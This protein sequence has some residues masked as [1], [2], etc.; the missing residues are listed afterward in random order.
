[1]TRMKTQILS[2]CCLALMVCHSCNT[3]PNAAADLPAAKFSA[4]LELPMAVDY[5]G[6][7]MLRS[8]PWLCKCC[9]VWWK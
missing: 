6:M 4:S 3:T 1:M 2:C 9:C 7:Q 8:R 5:A